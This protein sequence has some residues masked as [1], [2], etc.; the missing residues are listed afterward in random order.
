MWQPAYAEH[1]SY[2]P[3]RCFNS[4]TPLTRLYTTM[5]TVDWWWETLVWRHTGT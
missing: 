5:H 2:A 3:H 4:N 1:L